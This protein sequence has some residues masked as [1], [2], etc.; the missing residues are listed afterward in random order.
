[1][2]PFGNTRPKVLDR[3]WSELLSPCWASPDPEESMRLPRGGSQAPGGRSLE[4]KLIQVGDWIKRQGRKD[5]GADC[6]EKIGHLSQRRRWSAVDQ[7]VNLGLRTTVWKQRWSIYHHFHDPLLC[8]PCVQVSSARLEVLVLKGAPV[9]P[10]DTTRVPLSY[11]FSPGAYM[12]GGKGNWPWSAEGGRTAFRA[13]FW[14]CVIKPICA[15]Q[16]GR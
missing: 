15:V 4:A 1:M 7:E 10:R 3:C 14:Q 9:L 2:E 16:E 6:Q 13:A 5:W 12:R 8:F 11:D